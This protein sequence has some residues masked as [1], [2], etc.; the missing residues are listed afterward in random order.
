MENLS[1]E[2]N[3]KVVELVSYGGEMK[4]T[5]R[6]FRELDPEEVLV[7]VMCSTIH[8]ADISFLRGTYGN[9]KPLT[10]LIPGFEGSGLIVKV[11][12]KVDSSFL[13]KRVGL[14]GKVEKDGTYSGLWAQ[15][16]Y[17]NYKTLMVFNKDIAYE[18]IA[19]SIG[20]PLTALGFVDTVRKNGLTSLGQNG[21]SSS[22][23]K[24]LIRLCKKEGIKTVNLV[25]KESYIQPLLDMGADYVINTSNPNWEEELKKLSRENNIKNFFECVG[26]D[27]T[28]KVLSCLPDKSTL[29]HFGNLELKRLG[30]INTSDFIFLGKQIVGWWLT[31]WVLNN[32]LEENVK[33]RKYIVE[34]LESGSDLFTTSV[35]K[36]FKFDDYQKAFE[37]YFTNMSEGKV[38]IRPNEI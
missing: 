1:L 6:K 30:Q 25:R 5:E 2:E 15:Y 28:G 12:E 18:T 23:G 10:P 33:A 32:S 27:Y 9:Q 38:I 26:G 19:F 20:N 13:G 14:S 11:G 36:T 7:K 4:M 17:A 16:T 35:S 31:S 3:Y 37:Y 34:D 8:P 29:Y 24:I 21:A 22:F